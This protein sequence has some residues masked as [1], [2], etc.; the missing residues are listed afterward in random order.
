VHIPA[1]L[2]SEGMGEDKIAAFYDDPVKQACDTRAMEKAYSFRSVSIDEGL[3]WRL[4]RWARFATWFSRGLLRRAG[5]RL[6]TLLGAHS[7]SSSSSS[8]ISSSA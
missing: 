4:Q 6:E 1:W 7:S 5:L 2:A 3:Y 8:S